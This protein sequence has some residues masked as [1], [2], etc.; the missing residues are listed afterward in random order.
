MVVNEPELVVRQGGTVVLVAEDLKA[1]AE[2][3][4]VVFEGE[5]EALEGVEGFG[6]AVVCSVGALVPI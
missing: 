3:E 1:K 6:V 2:R 5:G 4:V